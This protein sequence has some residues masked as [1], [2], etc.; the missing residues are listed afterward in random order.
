MNLQNTLKTVANHLQSGNLKNEAQVKQA[1]ILP[2]LRMLGWDDTDP[3]VLK[4]EYSVDQGAV[5][6]ALLDRGKPHVFIEAKSIGKLGPKGE[7][8]L[9]RYAS[10]KGVPLLLLTD[11]NRWD[12]YLSMALGVPEERRF[13]R[14]ELENEHKIKEYVEFLE[15]YLQKDRV[16]SGIAIRDAEKRHASNLE[17]DRARKRIPIVWRSLLEKPDD[18]L[19]DLLAETVESEC[20]TKPELDDVKDFLRKI[21]INGITPAPEP[22]PPKP[23]PKPSPPKP[24]EPTQGKITG[25]VLRDQEFNT[26]FAITTLAQ[27]VEIF[28]H[29]TPEFMQSFAERTATKKRN[30]VAKN[31]AD[32]YQTRHLVDSHSKQ[33]NNGWWLGTNRSK[34]QIQGHIE[35]AC[36]I[37]GVRFGTQL[38]LIER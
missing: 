17:R 10:N 28:A 24:D 18:I 38:K 26:G 13:Y 3:N 21:L 9:F 23:R 30:L 5:D 4:P 11:G 31:R 34:L 36:D 22:R 16:I 12:F 1:A 29:E 37:A 27:I 8:Q 33:L 20:G 32:L 35:T 15:K 2:V 25:F 7:D 19:C 6:Y 14:L